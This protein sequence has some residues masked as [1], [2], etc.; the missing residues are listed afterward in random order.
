MVAGTLELSAGQYVN[1]L[2]CTISWFIPDTLTDSSNMVEQAFTM[3][4]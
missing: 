3:Q 2:S 1:K 4:R